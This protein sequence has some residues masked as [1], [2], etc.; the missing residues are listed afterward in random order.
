MKSR[1]Q[2]MRYF[3]V[4]FPFLGALSKRGFYALKHNHILN[5]FILF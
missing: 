4:K 5:H 1:I 3:D 2:K